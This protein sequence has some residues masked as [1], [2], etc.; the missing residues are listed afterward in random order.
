MDF[1]LLLPFRNPKQW[2]VPFPQLYE[3]H[4]AQAVLAE[5][6]GYDHVWTTEHHFAEDA[7]SPSL[8]PILSAMAVRTSR[9]RLGT[10]III[11]P[12]H[13]P[14]R[15]AEDAATVDI[16]SNGRL[17]LGL[18]QGYWLSEF[19]SFGIPRKERAARLEEGTEIIR[20]C[21]TEDN[22]SFAGRYYD[23]R[24]VVLAPKPVQRPHPPIW[25][26]AMAEKSV[27]RA[28]RL[29]YHLGGSGGVDLQQMYDAGLAEHGRSTDDYH[30]AQLRAVYVAETREQAWDDVEHHLHYMMSSYDRRFKES[31]DLPWSDAVMSTPTVPPPGELRHVKDLS[32]FQAPLIVGTPDGAIREIERYRQATRVTHLVMWMQMAG[33]D[34]QKVRGS[35][36]LF[37]KEVMPH[38]RG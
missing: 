13:H 9:I 14:V 6:L 27:V 38:F 8:L 24:E 1:G 21:F 37:A 26:A 5:D 28:A 31:G 29:G 4:I 7:W 17:D 32:F 18:G 3:A 22:F 25:I 10:Y 19:A 11:L 33:L 16:L 20:R 23:L 36:E 2:Q 35:M 30:V 12:L 15:V 34:P